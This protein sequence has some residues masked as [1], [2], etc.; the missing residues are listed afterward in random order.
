MSEKPL[1]INGKTY[2]SSRRAGE[3]FGYTNDY[4]GQLARAGKIES[5]IVGRSRYV[6]YSSISDYVRIANGAIKRL[7]RNIEAQIAPSI[8]SRSLDIIPVAKVVDESKTNY[9]STK[10][11]KLISVHQINSS[12]IVK[13]ICLPVYNERR[14]SLIKVLA[15]ACAVLAVMLFFTGSLFGDGN[16]ILSNLGEKFGTTT[17]ERFAYNEV[18]AVNSTTFKSILDSG[19]EI[20]MKYLGFLDKVENS[21]VGFFSNTRSRIAGSIRGLFGRDEIYVAQIDPNQVAVS[22]PA[23][24]DVDVNAS[25]STLTEDDVR[26][27]ASH[28]IDETLA[29][30]IDYFSQARNSHEGIVTSP[31][32]SD[33][34][35][36]ERIKNQVRNSFSDRVNIDLSADRSSGV[37]TPVFRDARDDQYFFVIVPVNEGNNE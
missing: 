34:I 6:D 17:Y 20:D 22:D 18:L 4:I 5:T 11:R 28:V 30:R 13:D 14:V 7:D 23:K 27:I 8:S 26:T 36:N 29:E 3:I 25:L 35:A 12:V 10:D 37:I 1:I 15:G 33:P 2:I 31:L 24:D 19:T 16:F 9:A 21:I 32:G